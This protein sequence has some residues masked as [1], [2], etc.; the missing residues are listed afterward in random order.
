[1]IFVTISEIACNLNLVYAVAMGDDIN[2]HIYHTINIR[3]VDLCRS[4]YTHMQV[5]MHKH[6]LYINNLYTL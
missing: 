6:T 3:R 2:C 1:M 5:Y 4:L